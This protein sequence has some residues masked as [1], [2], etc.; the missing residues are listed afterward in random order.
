MWGGRYVIGDDELAEFSSQE[1]LLGLSTYLDDEDFSLNQ[2]DL[3]DKSCI[4]KIKF[5]CE[6][7]KLWKKLNVWEEAGK[8]FD[9]ENTHSVDYSGYLLNHTKKLVID[10]ADYYKLSKFLSARGTY[11]SIDA[12]PVLTE[13][14]G[15]TQMALFDGVASDSTEELAGEWVGDLLQIVASVADLPESYKLINCCFADIWSRA[16][17]CYHTFGVNENDCIKNADKL[18]E[19]AALNL[20]GKRGPTSYIKAQLS[21]GK[22]KFTPISK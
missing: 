15:G 12:I 5:I 6:N 4:D 2:N 19:G 14:G 9:W 1:D 10:L 17:Y 22:I 13:T 3:Q 18:F 8:Y 21:E 16:Q 7:N 11:M 20:Y